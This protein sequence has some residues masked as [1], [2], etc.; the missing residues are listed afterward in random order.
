MGIGEYPFLLTNIFSVEKLMQD[1]N[2]S[3]GGNARK[4]FIYLPDKIIFHLWERVMTYD[5]PSISGCGTDS[6][7]PFWER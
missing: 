2:N 5:Y 6:G 1:V 7:K 4:Y 3:I